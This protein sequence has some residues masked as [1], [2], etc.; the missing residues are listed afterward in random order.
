[1]SGIINLP[2][3]ERGPVVILHFILSLWDNELRSK[4]N[5]PD[6]TGVTV[7][8]EVEELQGYNFLKSDL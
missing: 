5:E 1:M 6:G 8:E 3:E 7:L 2:V 4:S